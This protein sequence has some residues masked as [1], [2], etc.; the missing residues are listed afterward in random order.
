MVQ[1]RTLNKHFILLLFGVFTFIFLGQVSQDLGP[2]PTPPQLQ[3]EQLGAPLQF[4]RCGESATSLS[5]AAP[6]TTASPQ[7][8]NIF[9]TA[10]I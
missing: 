4:S 2:P 6:L 3:W 8:E 7:R 1:L 9:L 5:A 10:L